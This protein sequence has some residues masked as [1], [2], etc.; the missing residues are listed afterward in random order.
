MRFHGPYGHAPLAR[1]SRIHA[2]RHTNGNRLAISFIANR[3]PLAGSADPAR[4]E[5]IRQDRAA[6]KI[7]SG[8]YPRSQ[9]GGIMLTLCSGRPASFPTT[10][11][12]GNR[13]AP[14]PWDDPADTDHPPPR[15]KAFLPQPESIRARGSNQSI[16]SILVPQRPI[17]SPESRSASCF[18]RECAIASNRW[19]AMCRAW[20]RALWTIRTS[21]Q[22]THTGQCLRPQLHTLYDY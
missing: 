14:C 8:Y 4:A 5:D 21:V 9:P 3:F 22:S 15:S 16:P 10:T 20:R 1:T 19:D 18:I 7:V 2:I 6:A 11:E 13:H 12:A 17:L